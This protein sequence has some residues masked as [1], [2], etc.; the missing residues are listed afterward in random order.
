MGV[1]YESSTSR[2]LRIHSK[3]WGSS[4]K[5]L[6]H[7]VQQF[8]LF[9]A[10]LL[11]KNFPPSPKEEGFFKKSK[12][13]TARAKKKLFLGWSRFLLASKLHFYSYFFPTAEGSKKGKKIK[14]KIEITKKLKHF[15]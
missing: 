1:E 13:T 12:N 7:R 8:S 5:V 10:F 2:V 3:K 15:L 14:K 9:I 11:A 6:V 4:L